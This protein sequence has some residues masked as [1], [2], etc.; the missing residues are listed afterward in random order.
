[1]HTV[2]ILDFHAVWRRKTSPL[3]P[4]R[5]RTGSRSEKKKVVQFEPQIIFF[6]SQRDMVK[7]MNMNNSVL[8]TASVQRV[9]EQLD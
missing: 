8:H 3:H 6:H 9:L 4:I 2:L 7:Q 1:M 5:L